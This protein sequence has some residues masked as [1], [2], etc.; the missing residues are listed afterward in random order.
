MNNIFK[1]SIVL[2]LL[3]FTGCA[4]Y[5][6]KSE[7]FPRMYNE[8]PLSILILPPINLSTAPEAKEYF[9]ATLTETISQTGYY[10]LPLEVTTPILKAEG[11]YDTEII[12]DSVLPQFKQLFGADA[13]LI[14]KILEW[15]K[16]YLIAGGNVRVSIDFMLR[17]TTTG[18]VIWAY[19]GK[20]VQDTSGSANNGIVGLIVETAIKTALQ[21]Y[22][23]IAKEVNKK[24]FKTVP[25]GIY[26]PR[27]NLNQTDSVKL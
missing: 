7:I 21:D 14:A 9:M 8:R 11:L 26:N 19:K 10:F 5:K 2:L 23:P 20:V 12:S 25:V 1:P 22:F 4:T 18:K 13:V 17:S 16:S 3:I 6:A 24:V 27:Y 15:D